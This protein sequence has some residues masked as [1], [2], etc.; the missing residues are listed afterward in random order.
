M[1]HRKDLSDFIKNALVSRGIAHTELMAIIDTELAHYN[2]S[3]VSG[4][5][6]APADSN[7]AIL[8]FYQTA[9]TLA[10]RRE[11]TITLYVTHLRAF[12]ESCDRDLLHVSAFDV[13]RYL[14]QMFLRKCKPTYIDSTRQILS[15]FYSWA[16][17]KQLIQANPMDQ[18]DKVICHK[19]QEQPFTAPELATL[20][21]AANC[22]DRAIIEFLLSTG[23]RISEMCAV[24]LSDVD[25]TT[26]SVH[27]V[28]GKGGKSRYVYMT[29]V[30]LKYIKEYLSSY[31]L[32]EYLFVTS[33]EPH[34]QYTAGAVRKL[35][36][37]LGE[38]SGVEN[39][40][41]HRFRHTC[42]TGLAKNGMPVQ[43][44]QQYLGHSK[45]DTTMVYVT[46]SNDAV[47]SSFD[48]C[49]NI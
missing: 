12:G 43:E 45:I 21:D 6:A 16:V 36:C 32:H 39:V 41:P 49:A 26:G 7:E 11:K 42:A 35:L 48:R 13:Q 47:K 9:L 3:R 14:A 29:P 25:L 1:D 22:R 44:V 24:R 2:V 33:R 27:I 37:S 40:H 30:A 4:E 31:G 23:A 5:L 19:E 34:R 38:K 10:G 46:V 18:V 15:A 8:Q 20:R 28:D 17:R